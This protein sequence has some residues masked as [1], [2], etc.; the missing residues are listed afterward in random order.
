M[1][2]VTIQE[3]S[4]LL[5]MPEQMLRVGLQQ[6]RFPFG[7]AVRS[8]EHRFTYYIH[9]GRLYEYLGVKEDDTRINT[10]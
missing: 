6:D 1:S 8:S 3:A 7:T 2:R 4:K 5:D 9:R 10:D